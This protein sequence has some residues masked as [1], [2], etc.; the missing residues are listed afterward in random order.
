MPSKYDTNPLDPD[1]P[2][3]ARASVAAPTQVLRSPEQDLIDTRQYPGSVTE[4]QTR[5]F[6]QPDFSAYQQPVNGNYVPAAYHPAQFAV[7]EDPSKRKIAKVGLP[8][9]IAIALPYLPWYI[10]LVA[11]VVLLALLPRSETKVR[12]HAAQ[13][14][15]AHIGIL[16]I[17]SI[18]GMVGN[19]TQVANIGNAM[20]LALTTIL[21]FVFAVK[22][23]KGRPIHIESVDGLTNWLDEKVDPKILES[24]LGQK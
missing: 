16:I 19:V 12:F 24:K 3:K 10:G 17:S 15:A 14:L 21:M 9:N 6:E 5:Q 20:F 1:F 22:A 4:E 11:G 8:E 18:L 7:A 23:W 13:G 2:E